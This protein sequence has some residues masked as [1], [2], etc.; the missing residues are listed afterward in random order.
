MGKQIPYI[1]DGGPC[2][3]GV[4]STVLD[5]S[6]PEPLLLRE[7]G[8]TAESLEA[9]LGRPLQRPNRLAQAD[10]AQRAPGTLAHH[11]A[12]SVPLFLFADDLALMDWLNHQEQLNQWA[13]PPALLRFDQALLD[14]RVADWNQEIL[15]PEG[16]LEQAAHQL[17]GALRRLEKSAGMILA[18]K[19]P[20]TGLG[21]AINDRLQR[22][23]MKPL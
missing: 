15:S 1:L 14:S 16:N 12:P 21:A 23:S 13:Q 18:Q 9:F 11:Y 6:G 7:G 4:E 10:Q 3:I 17:F 5:L 19:V 22:A 2:H 8:L 20:N